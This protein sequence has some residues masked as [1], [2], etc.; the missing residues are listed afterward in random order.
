MPACLLLQIHVE[1]FGHTTAKVEQPSGCTDKYP[2]KCPAW[3]ASGECEANPEFMKGSDD[4]VGQCRLSCKVCKVCAEGDVLCERRRK[5][6]V[7][8]QKQK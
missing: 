7:D 4:S 8:M 6:L 2:K 3:A 5:R 1:P